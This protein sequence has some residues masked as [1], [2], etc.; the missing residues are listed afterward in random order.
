MFIITIFFSLNL[1]LVNAQSPII[2]PSQPS[3]PPSYQQAQIE[4]LN[5]MHLTP[6]GGFPGGELDS[7]VK[8][9]NSFF[10]IYDW[11]SHSMDW[12]FNFFYYLKSLIYSQSPINV[13]VPLEST[14]PDIKILENGAPVFSSNSKEWY[15]QGNGM[16][17]EMPVGSSA[18]PV[19]TR[20]LSETYSMGQEF[21]D[22]ATTYDRKNLST[23]CIQEN[24]DGYSAAII[25]CAASS[26]AF[27]PLCIP[28][29]NSVLEK[30]FYSSD[31]NASKKSYEECVNKIK[32]CNNPEASLINPS[33]L[34][35]S[36]DTKSYRNLNECIL[37][38]FSLFTLSWDRAC[39]DIGLS[40]SCKLPEEIVNQ[41]KTGY[42]DKQDAERIDGCKKAFKE[43]PIP[44]KIVEPKNSSIN[45][46]LESGNASSSSLD[47]KLPP[48]QKTNIDIEQLCLPCLI[49]YQDAVAKYDLCMNKPGDI[50]ACD[51]EQGFI[52]SVRK[53]CT[54]DIA[55]RL[56]ALGNTD[57]Y[58]IDCFNY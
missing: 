23:E 15:Y 39:S 13:K 8:L 4:L 54:D 2:V 48:T 50:H 34:V 45:P 42:L 3:V 51:Q 18:E 46:P 27:G 37:A 43:V 32:I 12:L 7:Q 6:T 11:L 40:K 33:L 1:I 31:C 57:P 9:G 22:L 35:S 56:E 36:F 20:F 52:D 17:H 14:N 41:G 26:K 53:S 49:K 21:V 47:T 24:T 55:K 5:T 58:F 29:G 44:T 19:L 28:T 25:N 30:I 38:S 10:N 16:W